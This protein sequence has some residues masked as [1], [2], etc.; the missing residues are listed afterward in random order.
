MWP[1]LIQWPAFANLII[2]DE[3]HFHISE[4]I[5]RRNFRYWAAKQPQ[6]A[7]EEPLQY[8]RDTV[9]CGVA[10][11]EVLS[12]SFFEEDDRTVTL[13]SQRYLEILKNF[14]PAELTTILARP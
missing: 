9:W 14:L 3:A 11:F 4:P 8:D 7:H 2:C 13:T 1:L 5:N 6:Q 12:P 10:A